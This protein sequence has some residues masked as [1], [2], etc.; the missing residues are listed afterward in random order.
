MPLA[1]ICRYLFAAAWLL[2]SSAA[3]ARGQATL[4]ASGGAIVGTVV[5]DETRR[6]L[7][8]AQLSL[9][10]TGRTIARRL[11][12]ANGAF[13]FAD[14]SSGEYE[15]VVRHIG[16]ARA[17]RTI[18]ITPNESQQRM[19]IALQPVATRLTGITTTATIPVAVDVRTGDQT[20]VQPVALPP[21]SATTSQILQQSLAGAARAPTGEVHIRGQHAEYT[22][23]IDGV[24]VPSGISGSLNEVIDP[25]V[26]SRIDVQTGGWDAEYGN[27]NIAVVNVATRIPDGELRWESS[28]YRGSYDNRGETVRLSSSGESVGALLSVTHQGTAMRREPV[29]IDPHSGAPLNFH[30]SGTDDYAFGK[31]E[32]R[33]SIRDRV[34]LTAN[35]SVTRFAVPFDSVGAALDDHQRDHNSFVNVGWSRD[36]GSS[37]VGWRGQPRDGTRELFVAAYVRRGSLD[38]EPGTLDKPAFVFY[39]DTTDRFTVREHRAATTTGVRLVYSHPL[40]S[41]LAVKVG[42]DASLADGRED[43]DTRDSLARP[44][45]TAHSSV[46]GGDVGSFGQVVAAPSARWELRTGLRVDHHVA[47]LAGDQHQVSPRVRL[48]YFLSA[49]TALWFYYGRLFIPSNVEDFHVLAQAAQSGVVGAATIPERD[50]YF[51]MGLTHRAGALTAKLAAYDRDDSPAVDDNT[52][53]GTALTTTV[54]IADVRVTGLETALAYDRGAGLSAYLNAALSHARAHGPITGGFFPTAYPSGW[55]DQDHDQRLSIAGGASY[56]ASRG[57]ASITGIFGSGLTN[58]HPDAAPNKTGLFDF[59]PAVKVAPSLIVN[60]TTGSTFRLGRTALSPAFYVENLFDRHYILKGAFTSG[61][62]VGR[63]R[64]LEVRVKLSGD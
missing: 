24:P 45:P 62:S 32:W 19:T 41:I 1:R 20:Y 5:D 54:N 29:M 28:A 15:L 31:L 60:A 2:A 21:P 27:K 11:S 8:N 59:N 57:Y 64:T 9:N 40:S 55:F 39:P 14:L 35:A 63:P 13:T 12:D 16:F 37:T 34:E 52:L 22:Y 61:P 42:T 4:G 58:G 30:N 33:P 36:L 51:E 47:P 50:H 10:R 38:Y 56:T 6:P 53:P 17:S 3:H 44:G 25:A 49:A 43:F 46:R 7:G 26:A 23:Y 48:A 18:A